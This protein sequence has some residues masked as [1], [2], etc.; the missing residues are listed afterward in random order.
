MKKAPFLLLALP[1]L[2]ALSACGQSN[3]SETPI[4]LD[5]VALD[6]GSAISIGT[7]S[8]AGLIPLSYDEVA[9]KRQLQENFVLLVHSRT[10]IACSCWKEFHEDVLLPYIERHHLAVYLL[11][12]EELNRQ[13]DRFGLNVFPS[14]ETLGIFKDGELLYQEN[15]ADSSS[16][17]ASDPRV[18][19]SWMNERIVPSRVLLIGQEELDA[20]Y[21]GYSPFTLAFGRTTCWDCAYLVHNDFRA[22]FAS[23]EI[24]YPVA[25]NYLYY[26]DCDQVGIR[27][28][29]GGDGIVYGPGEDNDYQRRA[30]AQ[31]EQFR[32]DYGLAASESN[33]A[34]WNAGYVPTLFHVLPDGENL[35]GD[36]IVGASVVYNDS[37]KDGSGSL[38]EEETYFTAARLELDC[39]E[40][41]RLSDVERKVLV[42]ASIDA[43]ISPKQKRYEEYHFPILTAF[44]D[45]FIGA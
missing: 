15:N 7:G 29:L 14:A 5:Q 21:G 28:V 39:M 23:H 12:Y 8:E 34:G 17:W 13:S 26:L 45:A 44:L 27:Y 18:F 32:L 24:A 6:F 1:A 25:D 40:Y 30:A 10:G 41:L 4:A 9:Y 43:S 36:V 3:S 19:A 22:Y 42:G 2:L 37:D 33:P 31:W 35:R 16:S 20:L 11:D 38:S